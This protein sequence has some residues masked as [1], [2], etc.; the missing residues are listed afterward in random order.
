MST[1]EA[2]KWYPIRVITGKERKTKELL[3]AEIRI[4][5]LDKWVKSVIIPMDKESKIRDG[6]KIVRDKLTYPGYLLIEANLTG[7]LIKLIKN[8]NGVAGFTTDGK[9]GAP[10]SLRPSEVDRMIGRIE[11]QENKEN[12]CVGETIKILDGPFAT[13]K[14]SISNVNQDKEKVKVDVLIFGRVTPVDLGF[15][16]IEKILE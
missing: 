1:I 11:E 8:C 7:E 16:Q 13:F 15:S 14:G 12:Y 3:E 10:Q 4:E 2:T 6:K 9:N 5:G